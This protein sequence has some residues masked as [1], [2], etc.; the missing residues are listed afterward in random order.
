MLIILTHQQNYNGWLVNEFRN[1]SLT[2]KQ[3]ARIEEGLPSLT[4]SLYNKDGE[5]ESH[6]HNDMFDLI[7]MFVQSCVPSCTEIRIEV[8][9][10]ST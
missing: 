10:Y 3:T 9:K 5:M 8:D 2:T 1:P 4:N 7:K 6:I